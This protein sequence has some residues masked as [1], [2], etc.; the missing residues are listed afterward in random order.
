MSTRKKTAA[1]QCRSGFSRRGA[2]CRT[3]GLR[4]Y[5]VEADSCSVIRSVR[6]YRVEIDDL[7]GTVS[8]RT[9][10][11]SRMTSREIQCR[12]GFGR[13]RVQC[14]TAGLRKNLRN[15]LKST[16]KSRPVRVQ[17]RNG[18]FRVQ[19]R[20]TETREMYSVEPCLTLN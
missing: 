3:T 20:T 15:L 8:K 7:P 9:A 4:A 10:A 16:E 5:S 14:R 12:S 19:C 13:R 11:V 17:C 1:V 18:C 6:K 2:Q